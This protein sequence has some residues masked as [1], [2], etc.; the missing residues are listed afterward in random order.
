VKNKPKTEVDFNVMVVIL[1]NEQVIFNYRNVLQ[2]ELR[3]SWKFK[4]G[5]NQREFM[6]KE[7][8]WKF[9]RF[10]REVSFKIDDENLKKFE[11]IKKYCEDRW[12]GCILKVGQVLHF[13][14]DHLRKK[15]RN[16]IIKI[17]RNKRKARKKW[18]HE[19]DRL[20]GEIA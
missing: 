10:I 14:K 20:L 2:V 11:F 18:L 17:L 6:L 13:M 15:V 1:R 8:R 16:N 5:N 9:G 7:N 12:N 19:N 4:E 3:R